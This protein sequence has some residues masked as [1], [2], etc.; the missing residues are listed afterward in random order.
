MSVGVI[1]GFADELIVL[2]LAQ[3]G[4]LLGLGLALVDILVVQ[5]HGQGQHGGGTL[6]LGGGCGRGAGDLLQAAGLGARL[7]LGDLVA[8]LSLTLLGFLKLLGQVL[9][10]LGLLLGHDD[11]LLSGSQLAGQVFGTGAELIT[12]MLHGV[13]LLAKIG[14]TCGLRGLSGE[15]IHLSGQT[16]HLILKL[17]VL[18]LLGGGLQRRILLLQGLH[19]GIKLGNL[20]VEPRDIRTKRLRGLTDGDRL[21]AQGLNGLSYLIEEIVDFINVITFL[22]THGL[23]GMLPNIFRRQQSHK[24]YTS[25][26]A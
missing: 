6:R 1:V 23:E 26:W 11:L 20:G 21:L 24:S 2:A 10:L 8:Q 16:I 14:L 17:F 9:D 22:E 5:L 25:L 18:S 12:L 13:E 7:D 4:N 19:L 3:L 15:L